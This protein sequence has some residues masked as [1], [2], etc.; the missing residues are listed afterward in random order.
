ML[1]AFVSGGDMAGQDYFEIWNNSGALGLH[2]EI[3]DYHLI[4]ATDEES[5][6]HEVGH[7]AYAPSF[8]FFEAVELYIEDCEGELCEYVQKHFENGNFEEIF[9]ELYMWDILYTIPQEFEEFYA[10]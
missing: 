7:I 4:F 10:R 2:F 9:A 3:E 8:E 5:A 6:L 1:T